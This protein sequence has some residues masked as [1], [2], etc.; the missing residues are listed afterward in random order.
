MKV[1]FD[2]NI[3]IAMVRVFQTFAKERQLQRLTAGLLIESAKDYT[4]RPDD[5]DY[6]KGSDVPWI[7]RF[8]ADRGRAIISGN[9]RIMERPH[10]R[11][12]LVDANLV[13]VFFESAWNELRFCTKCSLLLHW[14]PVVAQKLNDAAPPSFWRIPNNWVK[15][16]TLRPLPITDQRLEKLERQKA[17]EPAVAARRRRSIV[18]P[19]PDQTAMHLA[20]AGRSDPEIAGAKD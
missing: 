18:D 2:E 6:E 5:P 19:S 8:A 20:G 10:E 7:R 9:T 3:P 13:A 17:A 4:P 16:G 12:A 15:N 14:W 11:Q 1:A